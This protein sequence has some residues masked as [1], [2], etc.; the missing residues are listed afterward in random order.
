MKKYNKIE[1]VLENKE[2]FDLILKYK[3]NLMLKAIRYLKDNKKY[4]KKNYN[5]IIEYNINSHRTVFQTIFYEDT[6]FKRFISD[7]LSEYI[8]KIFNY[9]NIES[10]RNVIKKN[11]HNDSVR[12][13]ILF[14]KIKNR[15]VCENYISIQLL[16]EIITF[17]NDVFI[18]KNFT[19]EKN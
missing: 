7:Y 15:D 4:N 14:N 5:K 16:D 8:M 6:N 9:F 3:K 11:I 18:I 2:L 19:Y 17:N 13:N 12:A 10:S 1:E